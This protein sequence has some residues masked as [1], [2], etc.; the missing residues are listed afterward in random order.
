LKVTDPKKNK[1]IFS[2]QYEYLKFVYSESIGI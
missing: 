1:N 2:D